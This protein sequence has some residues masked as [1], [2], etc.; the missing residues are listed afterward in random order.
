ML[1]VINSPVGIDVPIRKMQEYLH[2]ALMAK[3][4]LNPAITAENA[5]YES[6]GRCYR[7]KK[8][9]GYAAEIFTGGNN[10]KDV[11][12][13]DGLNAISFFGVGQKVDHKISESAEVHL[14]F[15]VD[16]KKLKPAL[17]HRAD[18]EVRLDVLNA[19][20]TFGFGFTYK[21][22]ETGIENVLREYPGSYRDERL[23]HVD[24]HPVHC[25]R[26]NFSL[27]YKK[28]ICY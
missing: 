23:K 8:A 18:E 4:G 3:W 2:K 21:S 15:F 19:V 6:Y 12:W 5:K 16:L 27:I 24:M 7:N 14:V 11:Y 28:N 20:Q 22:L 13:N 25:F 17:V 1:T 9:N 10:Y 26:L